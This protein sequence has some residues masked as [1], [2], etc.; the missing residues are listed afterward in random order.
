MTIAREDDLVRLTG[1]CGVEEAE[2][3]LEHLA[4]GVV[5]VNLGGCEQL[6]AAILQLLLASQAQIEG[7]RPAFLA[8]WNLLPERDRSSRG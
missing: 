8:R 1:R 5:R 6:H 7:E 4:S 2:A 3:L